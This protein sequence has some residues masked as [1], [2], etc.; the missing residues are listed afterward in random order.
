MSRNLI[1][2]IILMLNLINLEK[3]VAATAA[4]EVNHLLKYQL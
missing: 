1:A 4:I 3:P 2:E